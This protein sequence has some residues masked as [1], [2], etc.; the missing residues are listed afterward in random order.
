MDALGEEH[1]A[2]KAELLEQAESGGL[3]K[4]SLTTMDEVQA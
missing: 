4:P 2:R 3:P 1:A